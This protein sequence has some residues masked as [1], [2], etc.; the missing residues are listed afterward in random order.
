[1]TSRKVIGALILALAIT[2]LIFSPVAAYSTD[3]TTLYSQGQALTTTKNYTE[4]LAAYN[5]AIALEPTYFEAWNGKAD[6]LNRQKQYAA[7]LAAS[8]QSLA[9]NPNYIKGLINQGQILYSIGYQYEDV[10]KD[11]TNANILY[12]AQLQAFQR[13]VALNPKNTEA[14]FNEGFAYGG[15]KRFDEAIADFNKVK[16][17]NPDYPQIDGYI[18]IA[19]DL[20]DKAAPEYTKYILP[21]GIGAAIIIGGVILFLGLRIKKE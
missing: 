12:N 2:F 6:V 11:M 17:I 19:S 10:A 9:I 3:A 20:R 5:D 8:N 18:K 7:A 1:M 13:A 4:A 21:I 16:A 14:L 15:L